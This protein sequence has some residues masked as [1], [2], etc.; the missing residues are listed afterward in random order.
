MTNEIKFSYAEQVTKPLKRGLIRVVEAMTG[1]PYLER[2]YKANQRTPGKDK[3]FW[4]ACIRQLQLD[5]KYDEAALSKAPAEGPLVVVANHPY[6]VLD[7]LTLAWLVEK[8]RADFMILASTVLAQAPETHPFI[9]PVDLSDRPSAK[10]TNLATRRKALAHLR[11][12]KTLV[13]FPAGLISTSPDRW[14][15]QVAVDPPWGP[16]AAQLIRRSHASVLPVFFCG[17]NGRVFQMVSHISRAL[18]L[19]L[20]FHEV[21]ARIGTRLDV[22]IGEVIS[23]PE[24]ASIGDDRALMHE[25]RKRTYALAGDRRDAHLSTLTIARPAESI[26]TAQHDV[27]GEEVA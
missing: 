23:Y 4:A 26:D 12:G 19:S 16:F 10:S 9:L 20:I 6:G 7:G 11:S 13:I 3:S 22:E 24:L 17:Q 2:L 27:D 14:G 21:K 25:L 5:V 18:R 15:R 8:V 1:Q